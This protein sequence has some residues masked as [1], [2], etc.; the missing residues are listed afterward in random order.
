MF[1]REPA[2]T[3]DP[4]DELIDILDDAGHMIGTAT[5]REVRARG[6]AHRCTYIFVFN[7]RGELFVHQRTPTKDVYPSHWDVAIGGVVAAGETFDQG[8]QREVWEELGVAIELEPLF[9]F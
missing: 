7:R 2:M 5:R 1:L 6:L 8:A 3:P 9:P 4:R